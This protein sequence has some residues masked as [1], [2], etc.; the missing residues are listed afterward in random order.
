MS[1][2]SRPP[3]TDT[4]TKE[5]TVSS[6]D[7]SGKHISHQT[8]EMPWNSTR[9]PEKPKLL[10]QL[11]N[12]DMIATIQDSVVWNRAVGIPLG[13]NSG[14]WYLLDVPVKA[15]SNVYIHTVAM[16]WGS[17]FWHLQPVNI[18]PQSGTPPCLR[19]DVVP[20]LLEVR[21]HEGLIQPPDPDRSHVGVF[22]KYLDLLVPQPMEPLVAPGF[23]NLYFAVTATAS[24]LAS[25]AVE[26]A[27]DQ[28][29]SPQGEVPGIPY[30]CDFAF[31]AGGPF[32]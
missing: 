9:T 8:F 20:Y 12:L 23:E 19:S 30:H 15:K 16:S 17:S 21:F 31:F 5:V 29:W 26:R 18:P 24:P 2:K 25:E 28:Y 1:T 22:M 14:L 4:A 7:W 11:G 13:P 3:Q 32:F 27:R 10:S 6:R